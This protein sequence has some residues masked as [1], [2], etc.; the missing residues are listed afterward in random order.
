M[1]GLEKL[2]GGKEDTN[3]LK[4]DEPRPESLLDTGAQ[5]VIGKP[6]DRIDGPLKVAGRATYA[7]EYDLDNVAYGFLVGST[8]GKGKITDLHAE[9]AKAVP[10]VIDVIT[11]YKTFIQAPQQGG[12]TKAPVQGVD[13]GGQP[14]VLPVGVLDQMRRGPGAERQ[15]VVDAAD[16]AFRG[17]DEDVAAVPIELRRL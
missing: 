5:D 15:I 14:E 6:L 7:A 9:V 2:L 17:V 4:M 1:L 16:R 12:E 8:V 13:Q 10:G 3:A 11:D